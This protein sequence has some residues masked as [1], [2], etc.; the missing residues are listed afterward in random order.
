MT[1][2]EY[3]RQSRSE[4]TQAF[5]QPRTAQ[6]RHPHVEEDTAEHAIAGKAVQQMLSRSVGR[7]LVTGFR[8]TTFHRCPEGRIV[9]D[10]MHETRH[11][12]L[13]AASKRAGA[14]H[15]RSPMAAEVRTVTSA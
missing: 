14:Q 4:F 12:S 6:S 11:R 10:N 7:D 1:S 8:Q 3:D 15:S 13:P 5:L 2:E 9:I